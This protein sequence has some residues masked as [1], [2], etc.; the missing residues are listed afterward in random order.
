MKYA[1]LPLS[2]MLALTVSSCQP[3]AQSAEPDECVYFLAAGFQPATA[4]GVHLYSFNTQ[5]GQSQLVATLSGIAKP[6]YFNILPDHRH[7]LTVSETSDGNDSLFISEICHEVDG[8]QLRN[9]HSTANISWAP[10]YVNF[11][12]PGTTA[13]TANYHSGSLCSFYLDTTQWQFVG[14]PEII[15]FQGTGPF[16]PNQDHAHAHCVEF[17]PDSTILYVTDLGADRI[18]RISLVEEVPLPDIELLP[19]SGP[20]H[21]IFAP[22]GRHAYLIN[23]LSGTVTVLADSLQTYVPIQ[24]EPCDSVG[25]YGSADIHMTAD[26]RFLYTSHRLKSDGISILTIDPQ[27]ALVHKIGYQ[28]TGIHPRNF[29]LSPGDR[30][31]LCACRDSN[32]IQVFARNAE[33]GELTPTGHDITMT[34]PMC[35]KFVE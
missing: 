18:H 28:L 31:L 22:D 7:F 33:T 6:T 10:A 14:E 3:T 13:Y 35:V 29:A 24:Y 12:A 26:G 4:D 15:E 23:E 16:Q 9:L 2:L 17:G 1:T 25:G 27:T 34:M 32:V 21:L 11:G 19:G 20:R 5:T 30:F 8:I